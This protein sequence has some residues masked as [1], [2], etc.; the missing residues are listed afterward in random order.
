MYRVYVTTSQWITARRWLEQNFLVS[1]EDYVFQIAQ[2]QVWLTFHS[3]EIYRWF[4]SRWVR[5]V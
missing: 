1:P 5:E 2:G 3:Y 4:F